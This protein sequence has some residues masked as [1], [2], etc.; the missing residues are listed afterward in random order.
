MIR[1]LIDGNN[2]VYRNNI[3][4]ELYT[5]QGQRTSGILGTLNNIR[6]ILELFRK[7]L[8]EEIGEVI[9]V[10]DAGHSKRRVSLFPD[11]KAHRKQ[12]RSEEDEL[13]MKE[14]IQQANS[15]YESLPFFGVKTFK[16]SG[17][18]ADD[19]LYG[20]L[21]NL[22]TRYPQD[23]MVLVSTDEDFHQLLDTNVEIFH[24]IK[25][26][27]LNLEN[28]EQKMNIP[29]EGFLFYKILRGDPS[30]GIP[31]IK[32]IGEKTAKSLVNE[33]KRLD[34]MLADKEGL[35]K[36][37][38]TARILTKEGLLTLD[39]NN[40]LIN[41]KDYVDIS[42]VQ[43]DIESLLDSELFVDSRLAKD[44][45]M[46]YQLTSILVKWDQWIHLFELMTEG[47]DEE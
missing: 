19:L 26:E 30:D 27:F 23:R 10:F 33:Y 41:L 17:W 34:L 35:N 2:M 46:K 4:S 20:T 18:E 5:K 42:D 1:I 36:S 44:Y 22:K 3:V 32:G 21:E 45:L 28:Y 8:K 29:H 15:L 38:R 16:R 40:K 11:Y 7:E 39:R 47:D 25:K 24:P 6:F 37:K 13:F 12:E 43:E 14:F 9:C 31:G